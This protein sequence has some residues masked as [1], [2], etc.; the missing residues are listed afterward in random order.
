M[1]TLAVQIEDN[2]VQ[3]FMNYVNTPVAYQKRCCL[4]GIK[5]PWNGQIIDIKECR[6]W[7]ILPME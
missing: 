6:E 5:L 1:Q 3:D 2:Y 7:G 4:K